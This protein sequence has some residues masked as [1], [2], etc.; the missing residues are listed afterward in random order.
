MHEKL[1]MPPQSNTKQWVNFFWRAVFSFR[2]SGTGL[3]TIGPQ[4]K[5]PWNLLFE[6]YKWTFKHAWKE[7]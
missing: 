1:F 7:P 3:S 6:K 5:K 4:T 2:V